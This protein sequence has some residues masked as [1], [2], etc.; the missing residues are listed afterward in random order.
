M[1]FAVPQEWLV[2]RSKEGGLWQMITA[3]RNY[4]HHKADL[5][6]LGLKSTSP[7]PYPLN[8]E[9]YGLDPADRNRQYITEGLL[10]AFPRPTASLEEVVDYLEGM[11]CSTLSLEVAHVSVSSVAHT[12][13]GH[14]L[15][16]YSEQV[17]ATQ[18][19]VLQWNPLQKGT[20]HINF[21]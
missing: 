17:V 4:G 8:P 14:V 7:L 1:Q 15:A 18:T 6:P 12:R 3:Y 10:F 21:V 19:V 20:R 5:D 16:L 2:N 11:Y 9:A 13:C